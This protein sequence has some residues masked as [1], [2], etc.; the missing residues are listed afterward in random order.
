MAVAAAPKR[1]GQ[2]RLP[3]RAKLCLVS[4]A[5]RR[6]R[7]R[8][9]PALAPACAVG[10]GKVF[11]ANRDGSGWAGGGGP[12]AS[13]DVS[14]F[15]A[16]AGAFRLAWHPCQEPLPRHPP[17]DAAAGRAMRLLSLGVGDWSL[18]ASP[19]LKSNLRSSR[20][21]IA[22]VCGGAKA[23]QLTVCPQRRGGWPGGRH[24][25]AGAPSWRWD[26]SRRAWC[27]SGRGSPG[28]RAGSRGASGSR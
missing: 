15:P 3:V 6:C 25:L 14:I 20:S 8:C 7:G 10:W 13:A 24:L 18:G 19:C 27:R 5:G 1:P 2:P 28:G 4:T 17:A 22:R 21:S 26:V 12:G 11:S 9:R 23:P 16:G